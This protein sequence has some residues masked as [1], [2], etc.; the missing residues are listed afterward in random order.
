MHLQ[1]R[2]PMTF[3]AVKNLLSQ[4]PGVQPGWG[5]RLGGFEFCDVILNSPLSTS[6]T[7]PSSILSISTKGRKI[8]L[9]LLLFYRFII[10][11][12]L[13]AILCFWS[14]DVILMKKMHNACLNGRGYF[15]WWKILQRNQDLLI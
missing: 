9:V 10:F 2:K 12:R 5:K 15:I 14:S 11:F 4:C 7:S 1:P 6:R 13:Y 8:L 3:W